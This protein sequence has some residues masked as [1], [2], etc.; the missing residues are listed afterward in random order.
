MQTQ[1]F[2]SGLVKIVKITL[3]FQNYSFKMIRMHIICEWVSFL[4]GSGPVCPQHYPKSGQVAGKTVE[5]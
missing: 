1:S 2:T 4:I 5:K 3:Y